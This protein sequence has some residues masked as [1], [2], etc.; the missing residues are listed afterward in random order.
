MEDQLSYANLTSDVAEKKSSLGEKVSSSLSEAQVNIP[1]FFTGLGGGRLVQSVNPV[2]HERSIDELLTKGFFPTSAL[3][4]SST[5]PAEFCLG[6]S[7]LILTEAACIEPFSYCVH[8]QG[9]G[10]AL[11]PASTQKLSKKLNQDEIFRQAFE[12]LEESESKW[13]ASLKKDAKLLSWRKY[14]EHNISENSGK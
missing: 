1:S 7:Q 8:C 12:S 5:I 14:D 6:T 9:L 2:L 3:Y 13:R 11:I 10:R 4:V